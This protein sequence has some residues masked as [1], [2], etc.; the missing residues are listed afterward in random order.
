ML[1]SIGYP[2]VQANSILPI[3]S[4]SITGTSITKRQTAVRSA[5]A[6]RRSRDGLFAVQQDVINDQSWC[7][8][9]DMDD[10]RCTKH[11]GRQLEQQ[12]SRR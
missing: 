1:G 4:T 5:P 3:R 6:G 9:V 10:D 12:D 11:I 7:R 2:I 8:T